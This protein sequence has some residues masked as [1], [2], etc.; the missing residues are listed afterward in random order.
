MLLTR[1]CVLRA[2]CAPDYVPVP[3]VYAAGRLDRDSE[4]LLVLTNSGALQS[5]LADPKHK[6]PKTYWAQVEG[7][8]SEEALQR[9]RDGVELN[10]G[11]TLPANVALLDGEPPLL[12]ARTPPVRVR[13]TVPTCW[14]E[15]RITEGRNR[16]ARASPCPV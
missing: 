16:Q 12:W 9:L 2:V 1:C 15:L 13:L 14:L 6:T 5:R 7:V 8:A 10:D 11:P 4:G 3:D